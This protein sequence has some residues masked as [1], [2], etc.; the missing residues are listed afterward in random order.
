MANSNSFL[1][2]YEI[3]RYLKKTN[4]EEIF[5]FYHE[6]VC[7]VHSLELPQ[8]GNSNEYTWHTIVV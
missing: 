1:S 8:W 4:K 7:C 2:P 5:L 6:T 3:L